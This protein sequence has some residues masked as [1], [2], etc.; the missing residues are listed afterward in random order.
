MSLIKALG[1]ADD[2]RRKASRPQAI[3]GEL[4]PGRILE[5]Q[6]LQ[7]VAQLLQEG[8]GGHGRRPR[9]PEPNQQQQGQ[10]GEGAGQGGIEF[11][12]GRAPQGWALGTGEEEGGRASSPSFLISPG[13]S[14]RA[15]SL[16]NR[17]TRVQAR[18]GTCSGLR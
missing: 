1:F 10:A 15:V 11:S 12:R 6:D 9:Q 7:P 17:G 2:F 3:Q 14:K 13:F 16:P 18:V 8:R 5:G 4:D